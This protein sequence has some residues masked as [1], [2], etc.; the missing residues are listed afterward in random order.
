ML[1]IIFAVLCAAVYVGLNYGSMLV[2]IKHHSRQTKTEDDLGLF[3][4]VFAALVGGAALYLSEGWMIW[5]GIAMSGSVLVLWYLKYAELDRLAE[6]EERDIRS[7]LR[8]FNMFNY[9]D[10][11][12]KRCVFWLLREYLMVTTILFVVTYLLI[13]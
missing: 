7:G 5:L 6:E 12:C 10:K 3:L 4:A 2:T 9:H 8:A 11:L 13:K 1:K